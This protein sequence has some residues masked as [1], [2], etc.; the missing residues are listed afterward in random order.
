MNRRPIDLVEGESE[1]VSGFEYFEMEFALI[2]IFTAE[3]G[4]ITFFSYIILLIIC[5]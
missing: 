5:L 1:L 3:Y 4:I 2:F